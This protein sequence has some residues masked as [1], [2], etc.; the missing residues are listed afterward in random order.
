MHVPGI[1]EVIPHISLTAIFDKTKL[2]LQLWTMLNVA[3]RLS[4][5]ASLHSQSCTFSLHV[6]RYSG[7][8]FWNFFLEVHFLQ[9]VLGI[10]YI[11]TMLIFNLIKTITIHHHYEYSNYYNSRRL[12]NFIFLSFFLNILFD[13][14]M[15]FI[16]L[17]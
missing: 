12:V 17:D 5:T 3:W 2:Q 11:F 8:F 13:N 14:Y 1:H 9:Y 4:T 15:L 6:I 10:C 16:Q 7:F